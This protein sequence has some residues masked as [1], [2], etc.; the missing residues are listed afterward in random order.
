MED[1][2]PEQPTAAVKCSAANGHVKTV[3]F[4]CLTG[5]KIILSAEETKPTSITINDFISESTMKLETSTP[6]KSF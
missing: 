4:Y 2:S 5:A 1:L 3:S 6:P